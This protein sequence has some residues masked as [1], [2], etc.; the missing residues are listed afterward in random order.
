MTPAAAPCT[1][2]HNQR[3][4]DAQSQPRAPAFET[5]HGSHGK[6]RRESFHSFRS[7]MFAARALLVVA[8][9]VAVAVAAP[10]TMP[11]AYQAVVS[12]GARRCVRCAVR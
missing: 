2:A 8:A 7:D 4:R 10:P 11:N 5:H 9:T 6:R 3:S 12:E 1:P